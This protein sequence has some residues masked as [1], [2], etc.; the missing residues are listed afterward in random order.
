MTVNERIKAALDPI[1]L[2]VK[3][4]R[5]KGEAESY[6]IFQYSTVGDGYAD[7]APG[8]ERC[9]IQ[10]HYLCPAGVNSLAIRKQVKR[11][12]FQ[13]GFSWP[14]EVNAGDG[15]MQKNDE[16]KQHYVFECEW[17]EGIEDGADQR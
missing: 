13:A 3:P 17:L 11:S 2:P 7:D 6:L 15:A 1:G 5:Y 8:F 10:V 9:L 14:E 4:D 12:L 16:N